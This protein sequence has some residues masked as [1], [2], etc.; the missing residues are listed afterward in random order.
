MKCLL[1]DDIELSSVDDNK[2]LPF[3]A[4]EEVVV[5][6]SRIRVHAIGDDG[7]AVDADAAELPLPSTSPES[8]SS[9]MP[10]SDTRS[11]AIRGLRKSEGER[12]ASST[13]SLLSL[14]DNLLWIEVVLWQLA[15]RRRRWAMAWA[16]LT[17]DGMH[18]SRC[19]HF[20]SRQK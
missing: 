18:G 4:V 10:S 7:K 16:M 12:G 3:D 19:R 15:K 8:R 9:S 13:M 2:L 17:D 6:V 20:H 11:S 1:D 5:V 14:L